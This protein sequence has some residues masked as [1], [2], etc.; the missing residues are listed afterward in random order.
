[1]HQLL[2]QTN[3]IRNWHGLESLSWD[4]STSEGLQQFADS[5]PGNVHGG[6]EGH[7]NLAYFTPCDSDATC[8]QIL[9]AAWQWYDLE[10]T[11]WNY[12]LNTCNGDW[13]KCGHFSNMMGVSTRTMACGYSSCPGGEDLVWCNFYDGEGEPEVPHGSGSKQALENSLYY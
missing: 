12:D 1:V 4:S 13:Y 3:R 10:E 6:P 5:C 2:V 8:G 9:S 7:Q 11:Y